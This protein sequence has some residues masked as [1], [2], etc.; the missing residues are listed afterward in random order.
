MC[1]LPNGVLLSCSYDNYIIAWNYPKIE[2]RML[3]Y[4]GKDEN[5]NDIVD[6]SLGPI[7]RKEELRCMDYIDWTM[8][9]EQRAIFLNN[10]R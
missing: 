9:E 6:A 8:P 7:K 2:N 5:D 1:I 4:V 3:M 10:R